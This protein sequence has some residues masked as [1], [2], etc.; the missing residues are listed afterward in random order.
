MTDLKCNDCGKIFIEPAVEIED[1]TPDGA[2]EGGSFYMKSL[3]CPYCGGSYEEI[4]ENE[5]EE[6][7][8]EC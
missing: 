8:E 5:D 7:E 3:V 1:L 4:K 2:F 6:E